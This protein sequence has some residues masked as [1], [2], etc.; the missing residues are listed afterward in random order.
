MQM[1]KQQRPV[2]LHLRQC[3]HGPQMEK[4]VLQILLLGQWLLFDRFGCFLTSGGTASK[5][6]TYSDLYNLFPLNPEPCMDLHSKS[7][8]APAPKRSCS[9]G[10]PSKTS[11][12]YEHVAFI[13]PWKNLFE[14]TPNGAGSCGFPAHP[15]RPL[16]VLPAFCLV[17][18]LKSSRQTGWCG[19]IGW[20]KKLK[21]KL[22]SL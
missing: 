16:P 20:H 6:A 9:F 19:R 13:G 4:S 12:T 5:W 18:N 7:K 21:F 22:L 8:L 11:K 2:S 3:F 17:G 14:V 10:P 1:L 15:H